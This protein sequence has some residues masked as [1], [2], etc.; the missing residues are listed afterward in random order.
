[1]TMIELIIHAVLLPTIIALI[2][3]LL[4]RW[5][6]SVDIGRRINVWTAAPAISMATI[7]SL[8]AVEG[9]EIW[10]LT[11]KW[12]SLWICALILGIGAM[13][14]SITSGQAWGKIERVRHVE[15]SLILACSSGLAIFFLKMPNIDGAIHRLC[16]AI[17]ISVAVLLLAKPSNRAPIILPFTICFVLCILAVFLI[18]SGSL[19]MALIASS[20][21][22]TAGICA[23]LTLLGRGFS[24]GPSF[25]MAGITITFAIALYGMSYHNN[26]N[27][28]Y[29][30]WWIVALTP[31]LLYFASWFRSR[32]AMRVGFVAIL[33][34]CIPLTI[35]AIRKV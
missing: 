1:M 13:I 26:S 23:I 6:W 11:Q 4:P 9:P 28:P 3:F 20:I 7:L 35:F 8:Y 14:A 21:S 32:I 25:S 5:P 31:L 27:V 19:K 24:G 29:A 18:V 17:G 22:M 33:V 12:Y 10:N 34:V 15:E 30:F 2:V 16:L